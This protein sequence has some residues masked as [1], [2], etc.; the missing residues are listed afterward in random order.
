MYNKKNILSLLLALVIS[1]PLLAI[2]TTQIDA[3]RNK[4]AIADTDSAIIEEFLGEAFSELMAKTEFSDVAALRNVIISKSSSITTSGKILYDPKYLSAFENELTNAFKEAKAM[5]DGKVKNLI[6]ANLLMLAYDIGHVDAAKTALPYLQES[7]IMIR[8]WAAQNFANPAIISQLNQGNATDRPELAAKILKAAKAEQ[9]GNILVSYAQFAAGL[10]D[11]TGNEILTAIAQK[12]I[13]QYLAWTVTD[14]MSDDG[15]LKALTDRIKTDTDSTKE[16]AKNFATLYSLVV[17]RYI[18]G[19]QTISDT[20]KS[21]LASV[22]VQGDKYVP[23]FIP[24]WNGNFKRAIDKD[25][26]SVLAESDGLFGSA[27]AAG[28]L[29]TTVGFE[30]DGATKTAPPVLTKPAAQKQ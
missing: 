22:I 13:E 2:S 26:A 24:E 3:I 28:K 15:I 20:S 16:M 19:Q 30:Y 25:L 4:E 29:S 6:T 9:S 27:A 17:Q 23:V 12:R 11:P 8:Y 1:S 7:N 18:Q 21:Y 14:E 5:K 10:K